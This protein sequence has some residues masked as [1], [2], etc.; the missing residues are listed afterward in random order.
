V[1][2]L[3]IRDL[4]RTLLCR[5]PACCCIQADDHSKLTGRLADNREPRARANT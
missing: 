1:S 5:L 4:V 3:K 2:E